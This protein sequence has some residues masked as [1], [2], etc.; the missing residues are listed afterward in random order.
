M[1]HMDQKILQRYMI[2]TL[3]AAQEE[4]L[5]QH[6][7]KCDKCAED[8]A[9]QMMQKKLLSP[10]PELRNDILRQTVGRQSV[11]RKKWIT[12][13]KKWNGA[14]WAYSA[15]VAFAM[16]AAIVMLFMLPD[17]SVQ[18]RQAPFSSEGAVSREQKIFVENT[19]ERRI[20]K[21]Q[22][23]KKAIEKKEMHKR[24]QEEGNIGDSLQEM[25]GRAGDAL[26]G[27]LQ[28]VTEE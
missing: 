2:G 19:K 6:I 22:A 7:A 20:N 17:Y 8:F 11:T 18:S 14:F 26:F 10:P 3:S 1:I 5:M 28:W 13:R 15:K 23:K 21:V 25:T 4:E 27:I 9:A 16:A 12:E 24:E